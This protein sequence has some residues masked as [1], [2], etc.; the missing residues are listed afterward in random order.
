MK[1]HLCRIL[2]HYAVY[3]GS[4]LK[5]PIAGH[6]EQFILEAAHTRWNKEGIFQWTTNY[7]EDEEETDEDWV[8]EEAHPQLS[9]AFLQN[10]VIIGDAFLSTLDC[11]KAGLETNCYYDATL[12]PSFITVNAKPAIDTL[13]E[14]SFTFD[15]FPTAIDSFVLHNPSSSGTLAAIPS[16]FVPETMSMIPDT[17]VHSGGHPLCN[18]PVD[19][20]IASNLSQHL[21]GTDEPTPRLCGPNIKSNGATSNDLYNEQIVV[22]PVANSICS[23]SD[24]LDYTSSCFRKTFFSLLAISYLYFD[25]QFLGRRALIQVQLNI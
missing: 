12:E 9:A 16:S 20:N 10:S 23:R 5:L 3:I 18:E 14:H 13:P 4:L 11:C 25:I 21:W 19:I 17:P 22:Q 6:A 2:A 24:F 7:P 8:P 15:K 1:T